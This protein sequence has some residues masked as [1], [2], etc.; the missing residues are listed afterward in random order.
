MSLYKLIYTHIMY[1][2][3]EKAVGDSQTKYSEEKQEQRFDIK[4]SLLIYKQDSL[5]A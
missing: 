1:N 2:P 3:I 4:I 5:L